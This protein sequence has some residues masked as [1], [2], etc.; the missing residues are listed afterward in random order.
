MDST[1][2]RRWFYKVISRGKNSPIYDAVVEYQKSADQVV[3]GGK[4]YG[5]GSSRLRT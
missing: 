5:T 3:I 1:W 4:E 2:Y